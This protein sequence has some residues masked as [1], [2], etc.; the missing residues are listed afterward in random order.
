MKVLK[1]LTVEKMGSNRGLSLIENVKKLRC[2]LS[3]NE[4]NFE[5]LSAV[6]EKIRKGVHLVSYNF[7]DHIKMWKT[8]GKDYPFGIFQFF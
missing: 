1:D 4:N 6:P 7:V 3:L 2:T 5:I 8:Q